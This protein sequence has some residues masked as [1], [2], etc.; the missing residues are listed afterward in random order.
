MRD[1]RAYVRE[2][3][4]PLQ[5]ERSVAEDV[6]AELAAHLEECYSA[7]RAQGLPDEKAYAWTCVRAGNWEELQSEV[8][9]A[10]REGMM[11]ERVKQ[12]WVPGLVTL[13]TSWVL[14]AVLIWAGVQPIISHLGEP[15]GVIVYLPWLIV[16]PLIG[17]AGSYL[18]RRAQA[19]GWRLYLAG[20][21]PA[22]AVLAVFV[23]VLPFRLIIDPFVVHDFELKALLTATLSWVILPGLALFLGV[24]LA[25][26]RKLPQPPRSQV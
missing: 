4:G 26:F 19:K 20:T 14:L 11:N 17:A 15:R 7:L 16:L 10:K 22:L 9:A 6:A 2:R 25:G 24:A 21:F 3:L 1:W 23:L 5:L 12:I 18:S 13:L 8:I